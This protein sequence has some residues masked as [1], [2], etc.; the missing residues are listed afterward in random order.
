MFGRR[1][2][3]WA[4]RSKDPYMKMI[5]LIMKHRNDAQVFL[6]IDLDC[7]FA[8][9]YIKLKRSEGIKISHMAII[10]AAF[11][12]TVAERPEIN[13]FIVGNKVYVRNQI[14]VS[15]AI[16]KLRTKDD[17]IETNV[18]LHFDPSD[19][20]YDVAKKVDEVIKQEKNIGSKTPTDKVAETIFKIPLLPPII[21]NICKLCDKLGILAKPIIEASPFHSSMFITN[22]A[23]IRMTKVYHHIYNFGTTSVFSSIGRR[24]KRVILNKLGQPQRKDVMPMGFVIDERIATGATYALALHLWEKYMKNPQLLEIPPET[25]RYDDNRI[26]GNQRKIRKFKSLRK[27]AQREKAKAI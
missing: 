25:I 27:K 14:T 12:R 22:M 3:G 2:D 10:L 15:F 6:N 18:K 13:R 20:I 24:E 17:V 16:V 7:K 11:V 5:P 9:E 1:F 23:S 8:D 26:Y 21:V 19:T 4:L